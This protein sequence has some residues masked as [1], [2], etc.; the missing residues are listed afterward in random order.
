MLVAKSTT[1]D[2][3]EMGRVLQQA[4]GVKRRCSYVPSTCQLTHGTRMPIRTI[5]VTRRRMNSQRS[6]KISSRLDTP[7]RFD[8]MRRDVGQG[9]TVPT[10][11]DG[12]NTGDSRAIVARR[13]GTVVRLSRDHNLINTY[14]VTHYCVIY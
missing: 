4:S 5:W 3:V 14:F 12:P 10:Q 1:Q 8:S 2:A 11:T 7:I 6:M 13:D 9:Q